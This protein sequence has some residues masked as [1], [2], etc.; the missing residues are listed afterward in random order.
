MSP[1]LIDA[2]SILYLLKNRSEMLRQSR[3]FLIIPLTIYE[4]GNAL[5]TEAYLRKTIDPRTA[6]T[7]LKIITPILHSMGISESGGDDL[8]NTLSLAG[9]CGLTFYDASYLYTAKKES[10]T[11]VTEDGK[12]AKA[13]SREGVEVLSAADP[14]P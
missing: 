14:W 7:L 11:L 5:R 13:A 12:L 6:E 9:K 3:G 4:I 8:V 1:K 10:C 2:S